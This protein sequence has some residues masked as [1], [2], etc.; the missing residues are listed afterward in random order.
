MGTSASEVSAF[1]PPL[2]RWCWP[3]G[4]SLATLAL[5]AVMQAVGPGCWVLAEMPAGGG[6]AVGSGLRSALTRSLFQHKDRVGS[7]ALAPVGLPS[8]W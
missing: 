8:E 7:T 3:V 1:I 4:G 2:Q 6:R 5:M